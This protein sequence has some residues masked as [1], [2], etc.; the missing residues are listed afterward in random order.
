MRRPLAA[1][2][3]FVSSYRILR[4]ALPG[5]CTPCGTVGNNET[6]LD[7]WVDYFVWLVPLA[8][9]HLSCRS[10]GLADLVVLFHLLV[11]FRRGQPESGQPRGLLTLN[12][13]SNVEAPISPPCSD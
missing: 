5:P 10:L 9:L 8:F 6:Q 4:I 7:R 2:S 1:V 13:F 12:K 3:I 11:C